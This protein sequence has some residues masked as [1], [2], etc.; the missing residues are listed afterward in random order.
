MSAKC[1]SGGGRGVAVGRA[2]S[3]FGSGGVGGWAW[4]VTLRGKKIPC[5]VEVKK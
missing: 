1:H 3:G 2:A 4:G 5:V